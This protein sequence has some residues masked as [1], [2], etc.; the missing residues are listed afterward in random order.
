MSGTPTTLGAASFEYIARDASGQTVRVAAQLAVVDD[1][2]SAEIPTL[3]EWGMILMG[4][5]LLAS[6]IYM[7]KKRTRGG[8]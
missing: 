6:M 1:P 5:L 3:S 8:W 2:D 4:L 7:D